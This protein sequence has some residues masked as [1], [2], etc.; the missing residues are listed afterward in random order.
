VLLK[1]DPIRDCPTCGNLLSLVQAVIWWWIYKKTIHSR[2]RKPS[3]TATRPLRGPADI[4]ALPPSR[5]LVVLV[6]P[7]DDRPPNPSSSS[8]KTRTPTGT[9]NTS[10][11]AHHSRNHT[12]RNTASRGPGGSDSLEISRSLQGSS[13]VTKSRPDSRPGAFI[14]APSHHDL[15]LFEKKKTA[16]SHH[17]DKNIGCNL[18]NKL[19]VT[20]IKQL[21]PL[22]HTVPSPTAETPTFSHVIPKSLIQPASVPHAESSELPIPQLPTLQPPTTYPLTPG[23]RTPYSPHPDEVTLCVRIFS[24]KKQT[25]L[26]FPALSSPR[27]RYC[28]V[29]PSVLNDVQVYPKKLVPGTFTQ[30]ICP[31]GRIFPRQYVGLAVNVRGK[32]YPKLF[33]VLD[34]PVPPGSPKVIL[35]EELHRILSDQSANVLVEQQRLS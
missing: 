32:V 28:L 12:R 27:F 31:L 14:K 6:C 29:C 8:S 20:D 33:I 24:F 19:D 1:P 7:M 11:P 16:I 2:T 25:L 23:R 3:S 34:A 5:S 18:P 15:A 9:T 17:F 4:S 30:S 35:G 22:G 21:Y 13:R 10:Q 26:D